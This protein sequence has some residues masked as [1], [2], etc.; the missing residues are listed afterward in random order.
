M[1]SEKLYPPGTVYNMVRGARA[2]GLIAVAVCLSSTDA[3]SAAPSPQ[4]HWEVYLNDSAAG[5]DSP[6]GPKR[7]LQKE[8]HRVVLRAVDDVPRRFGELTFAKSMLNDHLVRPPASPLRAR[9]L[10][11][12]PDTPFSQPPPAHQLREGHRAPLP[13]ALFPA[14]PWRLTAPDD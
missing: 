11:L 10:C 3:L 12:Y 4:E 9:T 5:S 2:V 7:V 13:G 6:N 14:C 8:A 1:S